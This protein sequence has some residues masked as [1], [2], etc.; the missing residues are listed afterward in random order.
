MNVINWTNKK[1][2]CHNILLFSILEEIH[3]LLNTFD[4]VVISHV[5]NDRNM[6]ADTLSKEGL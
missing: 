5:Y 3:R 2:I 6:I 4:T 1:Q